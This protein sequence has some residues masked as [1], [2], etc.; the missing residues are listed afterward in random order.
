MHATQIVVAS[1]CATGIQ[2]YLQVWEES[3]AKLFKPTSMKINIRARTLVWAGLHAAHAC[4]RIRKAN[5]RS[6]TLVNHSLLTS[7][8]AIMPCAVQFTTC[9]AHQS[10]PSMSPLGTEGFATGSVVFT[11]YNAVR[12]AF[13]MSKGGS[14]SVPHIPQAVQSFI[15]AL[16]CP[17]RISSLRC[18]LASFN[19]SAI[20][21]T[22]AAEK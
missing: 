4:L 20:N 12:L 11:W 1:Q 17:K 19:S 9:N 8:Q 22:L 10:L 21:L 15:R 2:R 16:R 3:S 7:V 13:R 14:R 5:I 18:G 6:I